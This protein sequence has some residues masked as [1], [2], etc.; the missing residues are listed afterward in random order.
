MAIYTN[1]PLSPEETK[2]LYS[3]LKRCE[4]HIGRDLLMVLNRLEKLLYEQLT[5]EEIEELQKEKEPPT[6]L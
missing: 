2:G 1:L 3:L 4:M 5:I 6:P